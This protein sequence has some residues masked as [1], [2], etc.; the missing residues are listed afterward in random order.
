M[1]T[2]ERVAHRYRRDPAMRRL[3][4]VV[5]PVCGLLA[6]AGRSLQEEEFGA[7]ARL[8]AEPTESVISLLLTRGRPGDP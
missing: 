4:P 2:A 5:L 8:A 3:C 6:A 1:A 7:V